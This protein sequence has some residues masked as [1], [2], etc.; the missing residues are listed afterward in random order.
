MDPSTQS[1]L[2]MGGY[3]NCPPSFSLYLVLGSNS[4]VRWLPWEGILFPD[5]F[6]CLQHFV[7]MTFIIS[8][9]IFIDITS[10]CNAD[11]TNAFYYIPW[12]WGVL[13]LRL[14]GRIL[15]PFQGHDL[16]AGVI[17]DVAG[18]FLFGHIP[19]RPR[20]IRITKNWSIFESVKILRNLKFYSSVYNTPQSS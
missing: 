2:E 12:L 15:W 13:L 11:L 20:I 16:S 19:Y 7:A 3:A 6:I 14:Q 9:F 18:W 17:C 1:R 4:T 5:C 8:A 10:V